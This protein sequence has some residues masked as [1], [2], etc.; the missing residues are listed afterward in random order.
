MWLWLR[1]AHS[2][3]TSGLIEI[4]RT[5]K[6]NRTYAQQL[7]HTLLPIDK[8]DIVQELMNNVRQPRL[9]RC[10]FG[11]TDTQYVKFLVHYDQITRTLLTPANRNHAGSYRHLL[12][13]QVI[14]DVLELGH[15]VLGALLNPTGGICGRKNSRLDCC[16]PARSCISYHACA[17][18]AYGFCKI[19]FNK[20]SGYNY[21]GGKSLLKTSNP[22]C[23]Q[24][25]GF[26]FWIC[27]RRTPNAIR[28]SG[29]TSNT[30]NEAVGGA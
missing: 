28:D 12:C 4:A 25:S 29:S 18:D 17:H 15:A 14:S 19:K 11:I 23:G 1:A 9:L 6:M 8:R 10:H 30:H 21:T 16:V 3:S 22:L 26:L 5:N 24:I 2:F 13:G 20:G 7:I 27:I